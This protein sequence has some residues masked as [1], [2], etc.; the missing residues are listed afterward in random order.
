MTSYPASISSPDSSKNFRIFRLNAAT[1]IVPTILA[2]PR[3]SLGWLDN[4]VGSVG[5]TGLGLTEDADRYIFVNVFPVDAIMRLASEVV[6]GLR[7]GGNLTT[8][9]SLTVTC[10]SGYIS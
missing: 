2:V 8:A 7:S 10:F 4:L 1:G 3:F 6:S 9:G 5:L